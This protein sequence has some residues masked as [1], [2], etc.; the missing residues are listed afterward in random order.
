M[1]KAGETVLSGTIIYGDEFQPTEGYLCI[2]DGII[3]EIGASSVDADL[4][5]IIAPRFVNAHTHIGDASFKD[6]PFLPLGELIGPGGLKHSL[7]AR[8]PRA[9]LVESMRRTILDMIDTGTYAFADFREGGRKGVQMLLEAVKGLPIKAAILGRPDV[10]S[11]EIHE[12]CWGLGISSTR[13]HKLE[14]VLEAANW[15]RCNSKALAMHA[16]E[17][18]RD[19]I[20]DS[21]SLEPDFLVHL[22]CANGDDLRRVAASE[23][24]VVVCPRSNLVTGVGLPNVQRM[25]ELGINVGVGTDNVMLNSP[26]MFSEMKLISKALLHDDRQVFKMC[27]LNGARIMGIDQKAGSISE[28]KEARLMVIDAS[29]NNMWGSSDPLASMVRRAR[30]SDILAIF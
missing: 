19:D 29:S 2:R 7:L 25:I 1:S 11:L 23:V 26:N 15:A 12:S 6:P 18:G 16:G 20:S 30:P 8:A 28:G 4:H 24:P 10:G 3:K 14:T 21:L 5:G 17:S 22:S 13:D 27:T 9:I